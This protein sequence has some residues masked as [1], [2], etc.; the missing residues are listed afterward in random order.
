MMPPKLRS[1]TAIA[2][3][4]G[5]NHPIDGFV[6]LKIPRGKEVLERFFNHLRE[7]QYA[8]RSSSNPKAAAQDDI[9]HIN[10]VKLKEVVEDEEGF[11]I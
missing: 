10:P 5:I 9:V 7:N 2:P 4:V 1:D 6:Q 8:K 11:L 3:H